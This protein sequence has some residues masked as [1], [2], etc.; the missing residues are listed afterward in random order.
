MGFK[1]NLKAKMD[2]DRLLRNAIHTIKEPPETKW[3]DKKLTGEILDKTDFKYK[4]AGNLDLYVRPLENG[5]MEILVLDNELPIYHTT[6]ADV[7]LRKNPHWQDVFSVRN[8]KKIMN[9]QD[10]IVSK[11]K[12]SLKKVYASALGRLDLTYDRGDLEQLIEEARMGLEQG[13]SPRIREP[14]DLFFEMLGFQP[15]YF[16]T[17]EPDLQMFGRPRP[18]FGATPSFEHLIILNEETLSLG[19]K[20][21]TFS[22]ANDSDL[23]WVV[24]YAQKQQKA[25]LQGLEVLEFLAELA[26]DQGQPSHPKPSVLH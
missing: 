21:G 12:E 23:G 17:L 4:K 10:V 3:V 22:P 19:L 11:G 2:L 13:S 14:L 7:T 20:K 24:R 5:I 1:E 18:N 16:E 15:V 26:L 9:D 25:D 8:V 6:V